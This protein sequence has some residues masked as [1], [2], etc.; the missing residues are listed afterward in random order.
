MNE[1]PPAAFASAAGF[2]IDFFFVLSVENA[3]LL[4]AKQL[5]KMRGLSG[6]FILTERKRE[7]VVKTSKCL[8]IIHCNVYKII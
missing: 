4:K 7:E 6:N 8:C 5:V 1:A 3:K 2:Q